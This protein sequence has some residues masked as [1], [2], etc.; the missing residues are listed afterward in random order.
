MASDLIGKVFPVNQASKQGVTPL[1]LAC[2]DGHKEVV[3]LL[4]EKFR[5]TL[6][7]NQASKIGATPLHYACQNGHKE[8][9]SLLLTIN[10]IDVNLGATLH[11]R[12]ITPISACEMSG[13]AHIA[14]QL[15]DHKVP[16]GSHD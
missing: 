5:D 16:L 4:L 10:E 7:V 1:H 15:R 3:A 6:D 8:I 9:V 14:Q 12:V 11:G 13:H 2:L